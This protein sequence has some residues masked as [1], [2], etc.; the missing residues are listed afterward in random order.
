MNKS[1]EL[2]TH[3][4][5]PPPDRLTALFARYAFKNLVRNFQHVC[6]LSAIK[7][8]A[9]RLLYLRGAYA[10]PVSKAF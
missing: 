2:A 9:E 8:A 6:L 3:L 1:E 5:V 10:E 7:E 4:T